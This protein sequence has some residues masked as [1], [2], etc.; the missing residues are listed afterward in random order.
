VLALP[1]RQS[2]GR[3]GSLLSSPSKRK[4]ASE[5]NR[6]VEKDR[7][8]TWY[9]RWADPETYSSIHRGI[10]SKE[11]LGLRDPILEGIIPEAHAE[12]AYQM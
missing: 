7:D 2:Q 8:D 3:D 9:R 10:H 4:N 5:S 1:Q 6:R 11:E 12:V